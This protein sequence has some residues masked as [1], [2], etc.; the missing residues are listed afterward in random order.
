MLND[1]PKMSND[2]DYELLL[3]KMLNDTLKMLN[4]S[5]KILNEKDY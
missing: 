2:K 5:P 1:T 4:D 3:L